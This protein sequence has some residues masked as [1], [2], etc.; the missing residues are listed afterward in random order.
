MDKVGD[1]SSKPVAA[2]FF[3]TTTKSSTS[4]ANDELGKDEFMKLLLAQLQ[5]QDPME[6]MKDEQFIAQMAQF[7][8][9][10]QMQTVNKTLTSVLNAQQLASASAL[11]G[12]TISAVDA[13]G[14]A[15]T[16]K[17]TAASVEKDVAM[18]HVGDK[19]VALDKISGVAP[20]ADS[21]PAVDSSSPSSDSNTPVGTVPSSG[22]SSSTGTGSSSG[23]SGAAGG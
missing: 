6:P 21:L 15:V 12:K 13:D 4:K 1:T 9:L 11:I 17:V 20:D 3:S 18:L 23:T 22:S 5:N 19:K 2:S 14:N 8:A 16:G 10:E 7:N